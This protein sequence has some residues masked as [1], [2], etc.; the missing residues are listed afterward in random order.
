MPLPDELERFIARRLFRRVPARLTSRL[1]AREYSHLLAEPLAEQMHGEEE[2]K[3]ASHVADRVLLRCKLAS[4]NS[5]ELDELAKDLQKQVQVHGPG[6]V[7]Q[8]ELRKALK[9]VQQESNRQTFAGLGGG[10]LGGAAGSAGGAILMA[11]L[12]GREHARL[13]AGLGIAPGAIAG[14]FGGKQLQ[15]RRELADVLRDKL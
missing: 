3:T 5:D 4:L 13:G 9:V 12:R 6:T 8:R 14:F 11:L 7:Q 10:V 15:Q 1:P 2:E